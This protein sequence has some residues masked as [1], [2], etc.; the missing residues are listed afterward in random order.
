MGA[1]FA[2][3]V[4]AWRRSTVLRSLASTLAL[5]CIWRGPGAQAAQVPAVLSLDGAAVAGQPASLAA[6]FTRLAPGPKAVKP[7]ELKVGPSMQH[8]FVCLPLCQRAPHPGLTPLRSRP[9]CR[10]GAMHLGQWQTHR[11]DCRPGNR[12]GLVGS[13]WYIWRQSAGTLTHSCPRLAGPRRLPPPRLVSRPL[14]LACICV[15]RGPGVGWPGLQYHWPFAPRR[16][17]GF[18]MAPQHRWPARPQLALLCPHSPACL[19]V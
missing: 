1:H 5:L 11:H 17:P 14:R 12:R 18:W 7:S 4:P 9:N 15:G 13:P 10:G 16:G 8:R 3:R 2:R 6:A 19:M